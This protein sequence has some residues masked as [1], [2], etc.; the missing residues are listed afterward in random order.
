MTFWLSLSTKLCACLW[1]LTIVVWTIRQT[2]AAAY[3]E[4]GFVE[5][6]VALFLQLLNHFPLRNVAFVSEDSLR[7][8]C[9]LPLAPLIL[10]A[11]RPCVK[12]SAQV[13]N[14]SAPPSFFISGPWLLDKMKYVWDFIHSSAM[15]LYK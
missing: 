7:P 12:M 9:P 2:L 13:L 4:E 15:V 11:D 5:P 10:V 1:M 6:C 8:S 14:L 3:H